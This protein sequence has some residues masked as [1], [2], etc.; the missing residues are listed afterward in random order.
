MILAIANQKGGSGKS[1]TAI[2]IAVR[3]ALEGID[4]CLV[5][6]DPQRTSSDWAALRKQNHPELPHV[7]VVSVSGEV[8]RD[9][10]DFGTRYALVVV[11]V[12]AKVDG[13]MVSV[14]KAADAVLVPTTPSQPDIFT[15][16]A[17]VGVMRQIFNATGRKLSGHLYINIATPMSSREETEARQILAADEVIADWL[18]VLDASNKYR[19]VYREAYR[20][21]LGVAEMK[22]KKAI[23]ENTALFNE[24]FADEAQ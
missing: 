5:D 20:A 16:H 14:M 1:T 9:I 10:L 11:D 22:D 13:A 19:T 3:A 12:G 23:A 15:I 17:T 8:S 24:L 18:P 2:N 4:V 7:P 6:V 21:G